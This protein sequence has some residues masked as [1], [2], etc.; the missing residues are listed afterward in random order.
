MNSPKTALNCTCLKDLFS[1]VANSKALIQ[2]LQW[3]ECYMPTMD[4]LQVQV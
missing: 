3:H 2:D 1:D 4:T